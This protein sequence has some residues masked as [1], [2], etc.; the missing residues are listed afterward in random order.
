MFEA[1]ILVVGGCGFVGFHVVK[2]LLEEQVWSVHVISRNPSRNQIKGANYHIGSLSSL[3]QLQAAFAK[4]Q[5]DVVIHAASPVSAGNSGGERQFR[6]TNVHGTRNLLNVAISTG[7]VRAFIYTSSAAVLDLTSHENATERVPMYTVTSR[8]DYYSKS[9]AIADQSV[10]DANGCGGM[11]TLCLRPAG[12]YGER[13]SQVIPGTLQAL[14]E[15]RHR[16]QIGDNKCLF[17]FVSVSNVALSHVLAVRVLLAKPDIASPKVDGEAFFITDGDPVPFWDF[18]RKVWAAAG[19]ELKP[20]EI[21]VVPAWFVLNLASLVEWIYWVFTLGL[22]RPKT[23]RRQA[24][25]FT[26]L[27]R[28]F[29]IA[30]ARQCLGYTPLQDRDEQIRKG[31]EWELSTQA[32]A[33]SKS[34]S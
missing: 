7:H 25:G 33:A 34:S 32:E 1:T 9:K 28:T 10:L 18:A 6:E 26:C 3:G 2:A 13:D 30:K 22:V 12:I 17:D 8:A 4:I 14:R 16:Y 31:V 24:I 20:E 11:R 5:P 23:L 29:S 19:V 15:G 27:P 21:T